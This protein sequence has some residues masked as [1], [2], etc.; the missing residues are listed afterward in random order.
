MNEMNFIPSFFSL[1]G[2]EKAVVDNRKEVGVGHSMGRLSVQ[3][4]KHTL[5]AAVV[6]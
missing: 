1:T 6:H 4:I 5:E 3:Q 2:K